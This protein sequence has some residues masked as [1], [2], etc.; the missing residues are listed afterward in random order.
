M[1]LLQKAK[2]WLIAGIAVGAVAGAATAPFAIEHFNR[3][4]LYGLPANLLLEPL[5]SLVI[6]PALAL[7]AAAQ[8]F[9]MGGW[10]LALAGWGIDQMLLLARITAEAPGAMHTLPSAP[11]IALPIAFIGIL[12]LCLWKGPLRWL[13][14][15]LALAVNLWPHAPAPDAWISSDG[16]NA[17]ILASS[18]PIVLRPAAEKFA[19]TLWAR[20]YGF[21][22]PMDVDPD[23]D[24]LFDCDR[25]GCSPLDAAPVRLGL[26]AGRKPPKPD[27]FARLCAQSEIV[28]LRSAAPT[29]QACAAETVLTADDFSRGGALELRRA[30]DGW[31]YRWAADER[32]KR[33]WTS[34]PGPSDSGG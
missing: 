28:V 23:H 14:L 22:L 24:R 19:A 34:G 9:G 3:V 32:G 1:R 7:G 27:A 18:G 31:R 25:R 4:S 11:T 15:P 2:D 16:A 30:P 20:R 8:L 21:E 33:P 5:S 12:W 6:M 17:A 26:W 13:G 29:G 10:L